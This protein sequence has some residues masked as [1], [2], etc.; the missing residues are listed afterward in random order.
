MSD[1]T[2][3]VLFLLEK[4]ALNWDRTVLSVKLFEAT[5]ASADGEIDVRATGARGEG[6]L[7]SG[8]NRCKA[9]TTLADLGLIF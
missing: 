4:F 8:Y 2:L 1:S 9:N 5:G 7:S 6:H 3:K